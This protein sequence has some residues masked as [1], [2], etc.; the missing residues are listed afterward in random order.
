MVSYLVVFIDFIL[1]PFVFF[2]LYHHYG[3][4]SGYYSHE[5]SDVYLP[6]GVLA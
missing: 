4:G 6:Q 1:L 3:D 2:A 5:E